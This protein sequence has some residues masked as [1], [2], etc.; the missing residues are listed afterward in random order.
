[1]MHAPFLKRMSFVDVS[2]MDVVHLAGM[3]ALMLVISATM[4]GMLVVT[5][6]GMSLADGFPPPFPKCGWVCAL[7]PP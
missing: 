7:P 3:N 2:D 1:M 5:N 6:L 4:L